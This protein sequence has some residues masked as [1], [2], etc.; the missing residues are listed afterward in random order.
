MTHQQ[1]IRVLLLLQLC[2]M[3]ME[4]SAAVRYVRGKERL[5]HGKIGLT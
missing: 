4:G 3:L 1:K 2:I 5:K